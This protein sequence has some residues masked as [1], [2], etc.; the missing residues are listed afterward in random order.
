MI[1]KEAE[2]A[3][4]L[5]VRTVARRMS[6]FRTKSLLRGWLANMPT[7]VV[8]F[9]VAEFRTRIGVPSFEVL[10]DG[11]FSHESRTL[12]H[13]AMLQKKALA[14]DKFIGDTD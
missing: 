2:P 6:R 13:Q 8:P 14:R 3:L 4:D 12:I 7:T 10:E 5:A 11:A 1:P 9:I